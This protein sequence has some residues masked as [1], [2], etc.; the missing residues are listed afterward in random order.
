MLLGEY[1][2]KVDDKGRVPLPP[3]FRDELQEGMVIT[4]NVD[5]CIR[6]YTV[7]E[8]EKVTAKISALP[9][10]NDNR[11]YRRFAYSGAYPLELDRTG[12]IA[13]PSILRQ[14]AGIGDDVVT[15]GQE[16][17]IELW[18]PEKWRDQTTAANENMWQITEKLESE[19]RNQR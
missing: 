16:R 17:Y 3:K 14:F 12:R 13:V 1:S 15:I 5:K 7:S 2:Y 10:T 18:N 8:W 9:D 6:I 4:K 19:Q 11:I